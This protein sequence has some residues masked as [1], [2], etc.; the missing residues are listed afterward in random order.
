MGSSRECQL[1]AKN[2]RR[3]RYAVLLLHAG[4]PARLSYPSVWS[5]L[6]QH[7]SSRRV[8]DIIPQWM[9]QPIL[10]AVV[11]PLRLKEARKTYSSSWIRT[12]SVRSSIPMGSNGRPLNPNAGATPCV[13]Y[14]AQLAKRVQTALEERVEAAGYDADVA[15]QVEVGFVHQRGS[16]NE[17]LQRFQLLGNYAGLV[18]SEQKPAVVMEEHLVVLPLY[19]QYDSMHAGAAFDGLVRAGF[20]ANRT[21]PHL[22]FIRSYCDHRAYI[23]ALEEHV[24][25]YFGENGAPDWLFVVFNGVPQRVVQDGDCYQVECQRTYQALRHALSNRYRHALLHDRDDLDESTGDSKPTSASSSVARTNRSL[26]DG[27]YT[28]P[29][30]SSRMTITFLRYGLEPSLEPRTDQVFA[31]IAKQVDLIAEQQQAS[32]TSSSAASTSSS[33][34]VKR[35]MMGS[36]YIVCPGMAVDDIKTLN[37][38]Q[39]R[40]CVD[41]ER[42]G[43]GAVKYIPALNASDSHAAAL[44]T[45]VLEHVL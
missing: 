22:E 12:G 42:Q 33:S 40:L 23:R 27:F 26:E 7:L 28:K 13:F 44:A 1:D 39:E 30:P 10:L 36:V 43:W 21:I 45:V 35:A 41:C 3:H 4:G 37:A 11:L 18:D 9:W 16:V 17:A 15:V 31:S 34:D 32:H 24:R 6:D 8:V 25:G 5:Y 20:F 2:N 38:I 14:A 19:P 29:F